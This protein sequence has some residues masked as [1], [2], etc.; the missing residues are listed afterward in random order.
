MCSFLPKLTDIQIR[1]KL[2]PGDLGTVIGM[3]GKLYSEEF[4]FGLGFECYVAKSMA[5]FF[6]SFD[7][8]KDRVWVAEWGNRIVGFLALVHRTP[9][10]AQL[11]YF[12]VDSDCRGIGLGKHLLDCWLA[13]AR[14]MN[15]QQVY[16]WTTDHLSLAAS[17]YKK[18]GFQLQEQRFSTNF[19]VPLTEQKYTLDLSL[20]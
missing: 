13:V 2:K 19:G 7:K 18:A 17:M 1:D 16:L 4:K 20:H 5:A 12:V 8:G 14:D 11:R 6:K 9:N 15:Y 10:V 3:H